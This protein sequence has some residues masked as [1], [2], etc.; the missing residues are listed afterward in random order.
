MDAAI[1]A[2]PNYNYRAQAAPDKDRVLDPEKLDAPKTAPKDA[3]KA[4]KMMLAA[5]APTA[6]QAK[7]AVTVL[8]EWF[9]KW[10]KKPHKINPDKIKDNAQTALDILN[11]VQTQTANNNNNQK[12]LNQTV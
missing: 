8:E 2:Y 6:K 9:E 7:K 11:T 4:E 1:S 3:P 12:R 5:K 10:A